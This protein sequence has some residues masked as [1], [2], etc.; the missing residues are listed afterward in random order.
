[1]YE[2]I[3]SHLIPFS[4]LPLTIRAN[5]RFGKDTS[6]PVKRIKRTRLKEKTKLKEKKILNAP[7]THTTE[8]KKE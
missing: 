8:V 2:N 5:F 6:K 7:E 1:M 4:M 3:I